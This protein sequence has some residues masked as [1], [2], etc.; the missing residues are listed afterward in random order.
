[1]DAPP[2]ALP[3]RTSAGEFRIVGTPQSLEKA[4]ARSRAPPWRS[5][6]LRRRSPV[7]RSPISSAIGVLL[8][9]GSL[10]P[11]AGAGLWRRRRGC[12]RHRRATAGAAVLQARERAAGPAA[13][14]A[15]A[16]PERS[17]GGPACARAICRQR[18]AACGPLLRSR[19]HVSVAAP[20]TG[21]D[22][23]KLMAAARLLVA[24]IPSIQVDWVTV[25]TEARAGGA[26]D[27][28]RRRRRRRRGRSGA[29]GHAPQPARGDPRQ[30]PRGRARAG[31]SATARFGAA[32]SRLTSDDRCHADS[33]RRRRVP[34]RAAA[35]LRPRAPERAV[36]A[37]VRR[38]LEVRRAAA[39]ERDRRRD[40][41]LDRIPARP[42]AYRIAP[43][44]ASRRTVRSRRWRC[45][46][47]RRS[48]TSGRSPPTRAPARRTRCCASCASSGSAS[49][50]SSCRWRRTPA[51]CCERCDAAL[52]IGDP[53]LFLDTRRRGCGRSIWARSG[54]SMTGLPFVWA[55]W[56]GRSGALS[57]RAP[58]AALTAARDAGVAASDRIADDYCGPERAA[59]GPRLFEGEYP[60]QA[61]RARTGGAAALLRAGAR[62]TSWSTRRGRSRFSESVPE[63]RL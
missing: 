1:M 37:A 53:A 15:R 24:N 43:E 56:A 35:R 22:D 11:L 8:A 28:R 31:S 49:T 51:R 40:D 33:S 39:R 41:S 54:P 34:Q 26:D 44:L 55:F 10:K 63:H 2:A 17:A 14:D 57:R 20:T 38:S 47:E 29:A 5:P 50:R 62:S 61:G 13:D 12:R 3:A 16:L 59:L 23:V 9:A 27:G 30:H 25:R 60:V 18:S 58:I 46:R 6:A 42:R 21:Y 19:E 4:V 7:F 48:R 52:L 45:S 32:V 36:L